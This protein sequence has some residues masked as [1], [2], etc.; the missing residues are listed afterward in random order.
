MNN[1]P[2][3]PLHIHPTHWH[4]W[5]DGSS[6]DPDL[7]ALNLYSLSGDEPYEELFYSDKLPRRNDGRL[8]AGTLKTYEHIE[9]G[10]WWCSTVDVLSPTLSDSL[11]GCFKPD[12]PRA[13][14]DS[15][16]VI[17]YE[18]PPRVATELFA[19]RI[20]WEIGLKV[21]RKY[22][23]EL[24]YAQRLWHEYRHIKAKSKK[25]SPEEKGDRLKE[26]SWSNKRA[27]RG[28]FGDSTGIEKQENQNKATIASFLISEAI[29]YLKDSEDRGFWKWVLETPSIPVTITEGAK[30]AGALLTAGYA[31]LALPGIWGGYRKPTNERGNVVGKPRLIPQL[32][33]FATGGREITFAFDQDR[34]PTTF[35]NVIRAIAKTGGLLAKKGCK[36]SVVEW[37]KEHKG[38]DDLIAGLGES[39]FHAAYNARKSLDAYKLKEI[40]DLTSYV[41]LTVNQRYLSSDLVPP[42]DAQIIGLASAKNTGKT[43]WLSLIAEFAL[44]QGRRVLIITHRVQLGQ[45]LCDRFGIDYVEEIRDSETRGL[46]GYGLCVDSLHPK[47]QARFQS[48]EWD[49]A[50]VIVDEAEQ[51]FWHML[52]SKTCQSNRVAILRTLQETLIAAVEGGG[53]IY[54]ADADLSP[55]A[56]DL[57]KGLLGF[58]AQTWIVQNAYNPN[59]G[60]RKCSVYNSTNPDFLIADLETAI[61]NGEKPLIHVSAQKVSSKYGSINLE[62]YLKKLFPERKILRIDSE[63]ISNPNHP[64]YGCTAHLNELLPNYDIVL[65]SPTIETGVSIDIKGHFTS[66]WGIAQGVQ[67]VDAVCQALERLR[68]DVPRHLF[69]RKTSS[70]R[71]GNGST[72]VRGLLQS[73]DKL[74]RANISLLQQAGLE[75][76]DLDTDFQPEA[77]KAWAKKACVV[78]GGMK[79]YRPSIFDKLKAEGYELVEAAA[80]ASN[81]VNKGIKAVKEENYQAHKEAVAAAETPTEMEALRLKKKRALTDTERLT[82]RKG[83]L[84]KRYGV[85]VTPELVEKDD[86]GWYPKL[87]LYYYLTLGREFV[88]QKD[89]R[90]LKKMADA[91]DGAIFKPDVNKKLWS[92][93]VRALEVIDIQQFFERDTYF[94]KE[95]L[96]PWFER[97]LSFRHDLK[98]VLGVTISDRITPI[99]AAQR[100][101][102]LLGLKLEYVGKKGKRHEQQRVYRG[103]NLNH[104]E[105]EKILFGWLERD[106]SFVDPGEQ[107]VSV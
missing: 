100:I 31:A 54:L 101:L 39:A 82:E 18:H 32:E 78:N 64:A 86:K 13:K 72:N 17:K 3:C 88:E 22:D 24:E 48:D 9:L 58:D 65:C 16:K 23:H 2:L 11:W 47:S 10:G 57:V 102:G 68:D 51:V 7:T 26:P 38:C 63:S 92:A 81:G 77:L 45:A 19:L 76:E 106:L 29:A 69:V 46:L 53:Q 107:N 83:D 73:Q 33:V 55:I 49:G 15:G 95:S 20:T 74:T 50:L 56:I 93:R 61:K 34:K 52:E 27:S 14:D 4:E 91:G 30:K 105:R 42:V 21:A 41:D 84:N 70:N 44:K 35:A 25:P 5:V 59:Q 75:S 60:K 96:K 104:D 43:E 12:R 36:V 40:T 62:S 98:T 71:V 67:T 6:I 1:S 28:G 99:Q 89:R 79:S 37:S 90:S 87:Q 97:L 66:V 8:S 80:N 103:C 94:T 85:E